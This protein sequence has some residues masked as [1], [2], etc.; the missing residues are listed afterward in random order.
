MRLVM[1][2]NYGACRYFYG[3]YIKNITTDW[4]IERLKKNMELFDILRLDHFR[5]FADYW[6]VA[7]SEKT[8]RNGEWKKGPRED[9]FQA[10]KKALGELPFIAEDLG[11]ID[12]AVYELRDEF[13]FPGMKVLQFAFGHEMPKSIYI[14]H[15]YS[16]NFVVYTG[17]HDNNTIK[18]WY[19]QEGSQVSP[20]TG[21]IFRQTRYLK[22]TFIWKWDGLALL[23]CC[24][25]CYI[26]NAGCIRLR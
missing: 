23:I 10:V 13:A 14:P 22:K 21:T 24:K 12:D 6:E 5:A 26:A 2:G 8:A 3:M 11:E 25:H 7:A 4:W 15:N 19:R 1:M 18:G 9:F 20:S 16:E 17:T